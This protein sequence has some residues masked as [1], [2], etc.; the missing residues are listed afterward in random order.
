MFDFFY[1]LGAVVGM[2]LEGGASFLIAYIMAAVMVRIS[3]FVRSMDDIFDGSNKH[4]GVLT[5]AAFIAWEVV[6]V[7]RQVIFLE[8]F[9][10]PVRRWEKAL[11]VCFG[12]IIAFGLLLLFSWITL[13]VVRRLLRRTI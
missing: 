12:L 11:V 10:E 8:V 3:G 13:K 5:F 2:L 4:M 6:F 7:V 9:T 1:R